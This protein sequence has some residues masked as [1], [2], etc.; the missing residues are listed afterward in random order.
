MTTSGR[1]PP[2]VLI[3]EDIDWIRAGMKRSVEQHGHR[4][5][6]S[7]DD[8]EAV[9]TAE[10]EAP[11]LILTEEALPT[12]AALLARVRA[13][14]ALHIIP[15]VIINPDADEH[16]HYDAAIVLT[17][18]EHLASLLPRPETLPNNKQ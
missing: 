10:R 1:R 2:T 14:P 18:Y 12:F 9:E 4:A 7:A 8:A 6:E 5:L 3:V 11:E 17:G 13:H 16:T 15:V